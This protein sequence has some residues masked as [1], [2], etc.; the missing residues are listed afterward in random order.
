VAKTYNN[1]GNLFIG[2]GDENNEESTSPALADNPMRLNPHADNVFLDMYEP[3][4]EVTITP[5][6]PEQMAKWARD[7]LTMSND[8]TLNANL[9]RG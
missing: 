8:A 4:P 1:G 2:G 9:G 7:Y 3:L 5:T 6:T